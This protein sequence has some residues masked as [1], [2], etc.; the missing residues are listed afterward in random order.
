MS[1]FIFSEPFTHTL[2]LAKVDGETPSRL[3]IEATV[4]VASYPNRNFI[5]FAPDALPGLASSFKGMPFLR[6]HA[7]GDLTARAGTITDA[8][9]D[10]DAI[11]VKADLVTPW[12]VKAALDG[13]LDRFSIGWHSPAGPACSS[14]AKPMRSRECAHYPGHDGVEAIYGADAVGVEIS[15]VS[16]PAVMG[17]GIDSIRMQL[18]AARADGLTADLAAARTELASLR[19]DA[20]VTAATRDGKV[21]PGGDAFIRAMDLDAAKAYIEKLPVLVKRDMQSSAPFTPYRNPGAAISDLQSNINRRLGLSDA[22]FT[23]YFKE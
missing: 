13:T 1:D 23:K 6:D 17:T 20:L 12:A 3:E 8:W 14:C 2:A 4:F 7:Q 11:K 19:M 18:S 21:I 10:G 15:A 5:R 22:D 16:V 9:L